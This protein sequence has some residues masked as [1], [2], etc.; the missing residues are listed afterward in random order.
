MNCVARLEPLNC[1]HA[2]HCLENTLHRI[3]AD[4]QN[5][6]ASL[7]LD[8][9]CVKARERLV[10]KNASLKNPMDRNMCLTGI[11]R[12]KSALLA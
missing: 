8:E 7:A 12:G 9:Q 1:R 5:K 2:L 4:L 11:S 3:N 6:L 10:H